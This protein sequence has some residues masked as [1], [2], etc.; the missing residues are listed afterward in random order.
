VP[1]DRLTYVGHATVLVEHAGVRML[2]DPLLRAGVA[3]VR[4][5]VPVPSL[6][7]LMSLDAILIS[8]AHADHLDV[9][10]L[11]LLGHKGPLIAPRGCGSIISR[12]GV[13]DVIELVAGE[14]CA[15]GSIGVEAVPAEHDGRRHPL[16]RRIPA[17][18][19]LLHGPARIYFAGDTDLF[20]AMDTLAG[21]VDVAL[22]PV[23]GW[24][25]R[26]PE[27]HLDPR[28]AARAVA[29]IRP[30]LA[31]PIHWGT[32]RSVG[33]GSGD[34][35]RAP[36]LAFAE[37]V[38]SV[39]PATEVRILEPGEMTRM[40]DAPQAR[41]TGQGVPTPLPDRETGP[42]VQPCTRRRP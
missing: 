27:G 31:I 9:P 13:R 18:G 32:M 21:R 22:L 30:A 36:A 10:S 37:A 24:G 34:D 42:K 1:G 26:L 28:T 7:P 35:P 16:G 23:W 11:R 33:A 14:Q 5:R 40:P 12:A 25:P 2:T 3:H 15:V 6:E 8:H 4:R 41:T 19:Y 17:L 20:D 39:A 29:T 38:T